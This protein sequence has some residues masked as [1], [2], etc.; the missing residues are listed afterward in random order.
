MLGVTL[1]QH[2][3][4]V[5]LNGNHLQ[6]T[7]THTDT[8]QGRHDTII[9]TDQQITLTEFIDFAKFLSPT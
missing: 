3:P 8:L 9:P 6:I 5:L 4:E 1:G 7:V 2:A